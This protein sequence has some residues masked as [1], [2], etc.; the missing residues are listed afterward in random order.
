MNNQETVTLSVEGMTCA[1]CVLRVEKTLKKVNGV[2]EANVNLA[3]EQVSLTYDPTKVK[4]PELVHA[5]DDAGYKLIIPEP[6]TRNLKPVVTKEHTVHDSHFHHREESFQKLK[7]D[8]LFSATLTIPIMIIS[9][10]SM[11][12]WF[13]SWS[14]LSMDDVNRLLL[15]LTTLIMFAAGK[16][17]FSIAWKL[18]KHFTSDMNTLVAVGTG[19]AYVYSAIAVLF[20]SWIGIHHASDHI[21]FDTAATIVTLILLGRLLEAKAKSRTADAIKKLVELQPKTARVIRNGNEMDVPIDE[22]VKNDIVVVRP[23]EKIPVDGVVINGFT[24]VD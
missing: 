8:F 5:V 24:T 19:T 10:A 12:D 22:V 20:P 15:I 18:A 7:R 16:R 6:V 17:F 9:M 21:Y 11:T 13:M 4:L 14:P 23:G 3:T 1:S 2:Q